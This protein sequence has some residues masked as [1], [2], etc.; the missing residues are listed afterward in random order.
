MASPF[1]PI[2]PTL[3]QPRRDGTSDQYYVP[4]A[5]RVPWRDTPGPIWQLVAAMLRN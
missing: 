2:W 5:R 1:A 3:R 4:A